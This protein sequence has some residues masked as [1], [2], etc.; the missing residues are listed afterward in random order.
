LYESTKHAYSGGGLHGGS[1][2]AD[3]LRVLRGS[4]ALSS[5]RGDLPDTSEVV[6]SSAGSLLTRDTSLP[7]SQKKSAAAMSAAA[8]VAATNWPQ[9]SASRAVVT[10][11][12]AS[13]WLNPLAPVPAA[14]SIPL[15]DSGGSLVDSFEAGGEYS[16]VGWMS[17]AEANELYTMAMG[18]LSEGCTR[19]DR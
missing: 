10:L 18:Q 9:D 5:V 8:V 6:S 12:S 7:S 1:D 3:D 14:W 4:Q 19:A 15:R 2:N 13:D 16:A 11:T 17:E